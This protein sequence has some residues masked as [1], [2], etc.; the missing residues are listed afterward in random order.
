MSTW[1]LDLKYPPETPLVIDV[2]G[3]SI[4][5][6]P[7]DATTLEFNQGD[8]SNSK[9]VGVSENASIVRFV[10]T[11]GPHPLLVFPRR[12]LLCPANSQLKTVID[13]PLFT[14]VGVGTARDIR[15]ITEIKSPLTS[16]AL[17][18]PVDSGV[19]CTSIKS[20][21]GVSIRDLRG[22]DEP[23]T[24]AARSSGDDPEISAGRG[25]GHRLTE[26]DL[27]A[28]V[29]VTVSNQTDKPLEVAKIMIPFPQRVVHQ[30]APRPSERADQAPLSGDVPQA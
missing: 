12:T 19:L 27:T 9:I 30:A 24:L 6:T 1:P 10:P 20:N 25:R 5:I 21:V 7:L 13:L 23:S 2:Y 14:K 8:A 4:T 28:Y 29:N 3:Q 17:Y 22:D 16:R 26:Q 15:E 11:L 18:G